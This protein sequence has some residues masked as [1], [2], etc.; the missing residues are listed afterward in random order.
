MVGVQRLGQGTN[1]GIL[2]ELRVN[3][4]ILLFHIFNS[5]EDENDVNIPGAYKD[6]GIICT[7][8]ATVSRIRSVF[9][10]IL[11]E[12]GRQI[13][14]GKIDLLHITFPI[15]LMCARTLGENILLHSFRSFCCSDFIAAYFPYYMNR[16][17]RTTD[18]LE[19]FKNYM[20]AILAAN[21]HSDEGNMYWFKPL[22]SI[23]GETFKG[24][25]KDGTRC[26]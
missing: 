3:R 7:N 10:E 12:I 9:Y 2:Q 8:K 13:M 6:V 21:Y 4:R 25:Y 11:K 26:Y 18:P 20:V 1:F 16:A 22:N 24:F 17:I 23:L 15:K 19:R 5:I 14:R